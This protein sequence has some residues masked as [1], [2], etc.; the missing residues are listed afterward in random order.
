MG[1]PA[2]SEDQ[3]NLPTATDVEG[4]SG[5]KVRVP[6]Q[7]GEITVSYGNTQDARTYRVQDGLVTP[8]NAHE[9]AELLSFVPGAKLAD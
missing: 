9:R 5:G 3:G 7:D 8:R 2:S 4:V 6:Q 1:K